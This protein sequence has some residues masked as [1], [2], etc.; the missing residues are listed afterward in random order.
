MEIDFGNKNSLSLKKALK[1]VYVDLYKYLFVVNKNFATEYQNGI[2]FD[3]DVLLKEA[4][5]L[6]KLMGRIDLS[7]EI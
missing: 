3:D 4:S 5:G 7:I 6:L 2:G 1:I